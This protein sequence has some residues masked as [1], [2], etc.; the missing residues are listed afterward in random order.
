[1]QLPDKFTIIIPPQ[2]IAFEPGLQEKLANGD[3][4]AF[5]WVYKNYCKKVY[6]YALLITNNNEQSEDVVQDVFVK[7]WTNREKLNDVKDFNGYLY[8][9][10]RNHVMDVLRGQQKEMKGKQAYYQIQPVAVNTVNDLIDYKEAERLIAEAIK[11]MP[12]GQRV[13]YM[14]SREEGLKRDKIAK[15]LKLSPLTVK[16]HIQNALRFLKKKLRK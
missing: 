14:M 3:S 9:L 11:E 16:N 4:N 5:A 15:E 2:D 7:L 12:K 13:V 10:Y 6:N 1:M 8:M